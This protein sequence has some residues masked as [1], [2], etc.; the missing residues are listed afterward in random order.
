MTN[1]QQPQ[2]VID[3]SDSHLQSQSANRVS[4]AEPQCTEDVA[5]AKNTVVKSADKK[6]GDSVT[7]TVTNLPRNGDMVTQHSYVK[8]GFGRL[9]DHC[10]QPYIAKRTPSKYCHSN[11]RVA[12]HRAKKVAQGGAK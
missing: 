7:P 4:S 9:C 5:G 6:H 2:T 12:A 10:Q 8:T 3:Q 1:L 11:C